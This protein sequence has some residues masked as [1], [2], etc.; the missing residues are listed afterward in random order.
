MDW[1]MRFSC[2]GVEIKSMENE[3]FSESFW[4]NV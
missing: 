2:G 1:M 4:F 3:Y